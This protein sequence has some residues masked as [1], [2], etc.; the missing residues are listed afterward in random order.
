MAPCSSSLVSWAQKN[1]RKLGIVNLRFGLTWIRQLSVCYRPSHQV[2]LTA[3]DSR[4]LSHYFDVS[5]RN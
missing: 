5:N 1:V 3:A 2:Q 4:P